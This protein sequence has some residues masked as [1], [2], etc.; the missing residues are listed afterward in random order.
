MESSPH[1]DHDPVAATITATLLR[2]QSIQGW[3]SNDDMR[4]IASALNV[5]LYKLEEVVSFF[6]HFRRS[7]PKYVE[8]HVCQDMACNLRG[9][10]ELV[11]SLREQFGADSRIELKTVSCLGRCDRPP[12]VCVSRNA[13]MTQEP[14]TDV[15]E[16][17]YLNRQPDEIHYVVERLIQGEEPAPAD[18]DADLPVHGQRWHVDPYDGPPTYEAA[19]K[20]WKE[21]R[22]AD[23]VAEARARL[24]LIPKLDKAGLRGMGGAGAPAG[25]KWRDVRQAGGEEKFIVCNADESE[26]GTFKDREL[27]LRTPHLIVEGVIL[28]GIACGGTRGYIYVRHEYPEQ[29]E[30]L[31]SA[32]AEAESQG[33][34]GQ[35]VMGTG[36]DFPVAVFVSPGGYICGEQ[37]ALI[38]AMEG[39]RAQPRN[40][41]PELATNGLFDK[42]TLVNNVETFAWVPGIALNPLPE[43]ADDP[44]WYADQGVKKKGIRFFSISGD[45]NRPGVYEVPIGTPLR[46]LVEAAGG[47]IGGEDNLLAVATSGP[48][49][50]FL[51]SFGIRDP[52]T[53]GRTVGVLDLELDIDVFRNFKAALGAGLVVYAKGTDMLRQAIACTRFYR[54][55]SCG[56]CVPCRLGCDKLYE[57]G[58]S[59]I[60]KPSSMTLTRH[61]VAVRDLD[62]ALELT[63]ICGLGQVAAKPLVSYMRYFQQDRP[64]TLTDFSMPAMPK[65]S[66]SGGIGGG[67]TGPT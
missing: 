37:S 17:L 47:V 40:R 51:P 33:V 27:L 14:G 1:V 31:W 11:N 62:R 50:G 21:L 42:P 36:I 35:N 22:V 66:S 8:V 59:L 6:P 48:S 3:I 15:H 9:S 54:S 30:A 25:K 4:E 58:L 20:Y 52:K 45:V 7:P 64:I 16:T 32:I 24:D 49:G 18:F 5:P 39:R 38:E 43:S 53:P 26:P 61:L 10:E 60:D 2:F 28:A 34:C 67:K 19:K 65:L 57:I 56:K 23:N 13:S 63:S 44:N 29:I 55:E 41:P 46:G 12:A